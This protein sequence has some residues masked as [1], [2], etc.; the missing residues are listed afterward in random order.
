MIKTKEKFFPKLTPGSKKEFASMD[1]TIAALKCDVIVLCDVR[2]MNSF[3][4]IMNNH[5]DITY[6]LL[7]AIFVWTFFRQNRI[8]MDAFQF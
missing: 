1:L 2:F 5:F 6:N 7:L 8:S 3:H 4:K